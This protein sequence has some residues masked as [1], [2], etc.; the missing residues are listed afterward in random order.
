MRWGNLSSWIPLCNPVSKGADRCWDERRVRESAQVTHSRIVDGNKKTRDARTESFEISRSQWLKLPTSLLIDSDKYYE[1]NEDKGTENNR[2]N[3][4]EA[5]TLCSWPR[6]FHVA[7]VAKPEDPQCT[8]WNSE[9][10][11][12]AH[13]KFED[14]VPCPIYPDFYLEKS[15]VRIWKATI[16]SKSKV[17]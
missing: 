12:A 10:A 3:H 6:N 11:A 5:K 2:R 15:I 7:R 1:K 8:N 14:H 4:T 13:M 16:S 17:L 9:T